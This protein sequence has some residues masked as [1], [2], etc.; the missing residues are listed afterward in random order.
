MTDQTAAVPTIK[1]TCCI[2]GG[3]PAGM[4]LGYL[5]ARGGVDVTV[6]EKHGDFLRDFRG[7]TVHPSTLEVMY[8]LGLLDDFLKREHQEVQQL[9]GK[10]GE[11]E[12]IIADFRYLPTHCKFIAL[13]P[14]WDF[15]N[16]LA[17]QAKKFP[18]FHLRM[19]ANVTNLIEEDDRVVGVHAETPNGPL[20]VRADLT[21]AS[22]GRHSTLRDRAGF[23]VRD[24]GSPIDVL[25]MRIT[26]KESDPLIPLGQV[27]AGS[28]LVMIYRS[29][30][31][32]CAYVI[33]KGGYD[34]LRSRGLEAFRRESW[35]SRPG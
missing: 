26:R 15:L 10:I 35:K 13:M 4:M 32:Q 14:Q 2:T 9:A 31:W 1:S 11:F 24:F 20:E 25:W 28:I 19:Q 17:E 27:S 18:T 29:K 30:Y 16:F 21:V 23:K 6:L 3:G 33:P 22:D 34:E 8:E 5:L 12:T 7:D